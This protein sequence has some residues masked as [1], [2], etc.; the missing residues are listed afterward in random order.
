MYNC[1]ST[2][3]FYILKLCEAYH[4]WV[5]MRCPFQYNNGKLYVKAVIIFAW[6]NLYPQDI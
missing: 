6:R 2:Y 4:K 1:G 5:H 3:T